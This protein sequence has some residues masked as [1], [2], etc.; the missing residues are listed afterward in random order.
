MLVNFYS[1]AFIIYKSKGIHVVIH[2]RVYRRKQIS[3][4]YNKKFY[5][6]K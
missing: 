2:K 3:E 6:H 4:K 1:T 5:E